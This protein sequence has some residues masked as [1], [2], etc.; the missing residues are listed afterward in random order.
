MAKVSQKLRSSALK[1]VLSHKFEE[2]IDLYRKILSKDP[3]DGQALNNLAIAYDSLGRYEEF[4]DTAVLALKVSPNDV[5]VVNVVAVAEYKLGR[6]EAS[7]KR[8]LDAVERFGMAYETAMNLCSVCGELNLHTEGLRYALEAVQLNPTKPSAHNNLGSAF[9][10]LGKEAEAKHCFETTLILEPDNP[11]AH[12]NIGV[13]ENKSGH[14]ESALAHFQK[15][16]DLMP[17]VET[18][19][20]VRNRF[21]MGLS[22]LAL[23]QLEAG[24]A[25]YEFG[26]QMPSGN[27]RN[28]KR[29]F[30]VPR[31]T[32]ESLVEKSIL[33][34]RE[35]GLG[36]EIFFFTAVRDLLSLGGN[37]IIEC[38][39]R[40][41]P[42]LR[43][44]YPTAT[45]RPQQYYAVPPHKSFHN[46]FDFQIPV[47]SLF[48][49]FRKSAEDFKKSGPYFV[50]S[51]ENARVFDTRLGPRGQSL[52]VGICWRSGDLSA[53]RNVHY[54]PLSAWENVFAVEG[55]QFVN[56]QYGDTA[57]EVMGAES[58]CGVSLNSWSDINRKDDLDEVA[59]LISQL[60]LVITVGTAVAQ[61]A[62]A[63][64]VP[65]WLMHVSQDWPQFGQKTYPVYPNV[66]MLRVPPGG[67]VA[68]LLE[69]SVPALLSELVQQ[70]AVTPRNAGT[71]RIH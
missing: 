21:F 68:E 64:G 62:A 11:F 24:W 4:F 23:G 35:Q 50:V 22:Q 8:L 55:V 31:W 42:T 20:S 19:D 30:Q 54:S 38:D 65:V 67:S 2:A 40:I 27:G 71:D 48:A 32:G 61:I 58:E 3:R 16:L 39:P 6:H 41:V 17:A 53:T 56:L 69:T 28:P 7:Y 12:T 1:A 43:R 45:V 47:G 44:S 26:W 34:W 15:S 14:H 70:R 5:D 29:T 13:L 37:V 49:H 57:K 59:A 9:M 46:D 66:E 63:V 52:R 25:N 51:E 10:S 60:D 33:V 36:D 18:L